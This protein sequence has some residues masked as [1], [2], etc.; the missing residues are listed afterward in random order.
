[1]IH[2]KALLTHVL[3]PTTNTDAAGEILWAYDSADP[4]VV[5]I[6]TKPEPWV[7]S[8]DLLAEALVTPGSPMVGEG[9]VK[10]QVDGE[11]VRIFLDAYEGA[12]QLRLIKQDLI[13]FVD[14]TVKIVG[15][16]EAESKI[17]QDELSDVL[18]MILS[19]S[20]ET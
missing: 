12:A 5:K 17:A 1:M 11:W 2:Q 8:R 9:D 14:E 6:Q 18:S 3:S 15:P 10:A 16:E 7:F 19:E 20:K 4:F 13:N